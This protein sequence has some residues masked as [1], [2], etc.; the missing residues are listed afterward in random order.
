MSLNTNIYKPRPIQMWV[1]NNLRRFNVVIMHRTTG[2]SVLAINEL[3]K[4]AAACEDRS[5]VP[6]VYVC[7]T[8]VQAKR[9]MWD[10]LKYY[11]EGIDAKIREDELTVQFKHNNAIIRLE[12]VQEAS[13]LRGMHVGMLVV[14]EVGDMRREDWEEV[15]FPTTHAH[16]ARII[17]IGTVA[18]ENLLTELYDRAKE[19]MANGNL[20]WQAIDIGVYSSGVYTKEYIDE[21]IRPSHSP[22]A[23]DREWLNKRTA[24]VTGTY[25]GDYIDHLT[26]VGNYAWDPSQPVTVG[27]DL[28][29][30]DYTAIWFAQ[31]INGEI[32]LIDYFDKTGEYSNYFINYLK[33]KPY[34]YDKILL[35]HDGVRRNNVDGRSVEK[36]FKRAGF[37]VKVLERP[38]KKAK[39]ISIVADQ[40]FKC[41]WNAETTRDGFLKLLQYKS[42]LDKLTGLPTGDP[43]RDSTGVVDCADAF[44]YLIM[45]I[46]DL[47]MYDMASRGLLGQKFKGI[48]KPRTYNV[49]RV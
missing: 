11:A 30:V 48:R 18:G 43:Q 32:R 20:N 12:G 40:L 46:K 1:H 21:V 7:P 16:K 49:R 37:N 41:R 23:F 35:P 45:G 5:G 44:R 19:F 22:Q 26:Q 25:Y 3:I 6:F 28:G 24:K 31:Q 9:N 17:I 15:L 10:T 47:S 4:A 2:K 38:L 14:D 29:T 39:E 27:M 34:Y 13:A 33:T 8:K 42:K 36:A